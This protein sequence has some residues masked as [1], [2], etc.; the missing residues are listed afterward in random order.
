MGGVWYRGRMARRALEFVE[1]RAVTCVFGGTAALRQVTARFE[2]G[3]LTVLEGPNGAGKSTLL[4]VLG[5]VVRPT[6]GSVWYEPMG[7]G[8]EV[9][10]GEIGWVAHEALCYGDLSAREN[11]ELGARFHGASAE[12][13]WRRVAGALGLERLGGR[14]VRTLSRGQ[15]QRVAL[16]KALV[17]G[18]SLLLLDEPWT[19]LDA[20][21]AA[22]LEGV[23]R[24][25]REEGAI[26]VIVSHD[27]GL[28][29]R[30]QGRRMRLERGRIREDE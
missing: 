20:E 15:K 1:A 25:E 11:V 22:V 7:V 19:G 27:A 18:P 2:A 4:G 12:E 3:T 10:R 21:V 30:L 5:A 14:A 24:K 17:H 9:A 13:G 23:V 26:V 29:A 6:G 16:A 8:R 28:A